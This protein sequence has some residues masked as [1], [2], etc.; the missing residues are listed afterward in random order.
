MV[1]IG[2]WGT[3]DEEAMI[4][5]VPI[6]LYHRVVAQPGPFSS[7][8]A[9]FDAHLSWLAEHGFTTITLAQLEERIRGRIRSTGREVVITFDDGYAELGTVV[10]QALRHYEFT[11]SAFLITSR[12]PDHD[13]DGGDATYLSWQRARA[14]ADEGLYE[15][16]SHTHTHEKWPLTAAEAPTL[17]AEITTARATLGQRLERPENEFG[18]L[19]WPYG[20]ACA[21][22]EAEAANVGVTTQYVVQR[23][24]VTREDVTQRLPRLLTDGMSLR[25]FAMWMRILSTGPGAMAV[26]RVFGTIRER[27]QGAAYV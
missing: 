21:P 11:A 1:S 18:H 2:V 13:D 25:Q 27:R 16:H 9:L 10:A 8:P 15:F 26:N 20:R 22:W 17:A 6:L 24:A 14:L 5:P 4:R 23:G 12:N 3:G 7:T 19:A